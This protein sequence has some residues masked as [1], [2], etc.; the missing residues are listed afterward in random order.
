MNSGLNRHYALNIALALGTAI[1]IL[2]SPCV[3]A[4][5]SPVLQAASWMAAD[6]ETGR[7]VSEHNSDE[8]REPASLTK[9]MTA[10][11][12]LGAIRSGGL[13][14]TDEV[15]VS[16]TDIQSIGNDEARM[17]LEPGQHVKVQ[18]LVR[19]LIV[20]SANDA[21]L[22]LAR[23]V[24]GTAPQFAALM[25]DTA[26]RLG[27]GHSHFISPSGI[28]TPDHYSTARDLT[29][30][31]IRLTKDFPEYYRFSNQQQFN[32]R[33]FTKNNKNH[34][35]EEDPTVDGL[36]TGHTKA[37]GWC[38]IAT[39]NRPEKN[40]HI[41]RRVFATVLGAFTEKERLTGAHKLIEFSYQRKPESS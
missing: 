21:A 39:A 28:S 32:Y 10:Y 19:G 41:H 35:L 15:I 18:D 2:F 26:H 13:N 25:N 34:L 8:Q 27:M 16:K 29:T 7:I 30:L 3:W 36:K 40:R 12:V 1:T 11:V 5:T 9:I 14:W 20:A 6:A 4:D 38:I 23:R 24:G 31:A 33:S 17:Y 22:V 37:A